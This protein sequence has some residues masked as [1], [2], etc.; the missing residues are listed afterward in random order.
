[1]AHVLRDGLVRRRPG[2]GRRMT[3]TIRPEPTDPAD[4]GTDDAP[5]PPP[6]ESFLEPGDAGDETGGSG[7][8][9]APNLPPVPPAAD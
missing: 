4:P 1:M 6:G 9:D 3:D 7:G 8:G 2:Y 5:K